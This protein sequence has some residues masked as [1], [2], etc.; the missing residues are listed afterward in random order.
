[1]TA[2]VLGSLMD[3]RLQRALGQSLKRLRQSRG[4]SQEAFA[5]AIGMHRTYL[6]GLERGEYNLTLKSVER[7]A[8]R[9]GIEPMALLPAASRRVG[10][11]WASIPSVGIGLSP[12]RAQDPRGE[13]PRHF[14]TGA[15]KASPRA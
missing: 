11:R 2:V 14:G 10:D 1:V 7:I 15:A 3:G 9:I 12:G 4:L 6:G 13:A 8:G 5:A